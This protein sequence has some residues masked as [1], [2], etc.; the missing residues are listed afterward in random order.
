LS[1]AALDAVTAVAC[2]LVVGAW[3]SVPASCW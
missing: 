3:V 1:E 2:K